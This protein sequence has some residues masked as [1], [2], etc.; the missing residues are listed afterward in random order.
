M[1]NTK[2]WIKDLY[3][4][5]CTFEVMVEDLVLQVDGNIDRWLLV[6]L[7]KYK[8]WNN[9]GQHISKGFNIEIKINKNFVYNSLYFI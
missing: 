5:F 6:S 1:C 2:S 3:P 8:I 7:K 9:N 4:L